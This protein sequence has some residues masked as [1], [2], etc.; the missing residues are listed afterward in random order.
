L[1]ITD[2]IYEIKEIT[3][4]VNSHVLHIFKK[5]AKIQTKSENEKLVIYK[6]LNNFRG[7]ICIIHSVK[8]V[9]KQWRTQEFCS[10][11]EGGSTNSVEDT[12][13]RERGSGGGSPVV[14][15]SALFANE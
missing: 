11:G 10:R 14:R 4:Y 5:K 1:L 7:C 15:G 6:I 3:T 8:C 2:S 9:R 12:G 13:Q